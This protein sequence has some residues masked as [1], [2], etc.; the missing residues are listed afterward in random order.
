MDIF[1]KRYSV[2]LGWKIKFTTAIFF[3]KSWICGDFQ[4]FYEKVSDYDDV[5]P[6]SY[7]DDSSTF[8]V[9]DS[10]STY[11]VADS[12]VSTSVASQQECKTEYQTVTEVIY[13]QV[14]EDV[15]QITNKRQC[16]LVPQRKCTPQRQRKCRT[17]TKQECKTRVGQQCADVFQEVSQPFS[18]SECWEEVESCQKILVDGGEGSIPQWINDPDC[19][20][21]LQ[22]SKL[23]MENY[24]INF[25]HN[26]SEKVQRCDEI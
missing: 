22:V 24:I 7:D 18:D 20:F 16:E 6:T 1:D 17:T 19:N 2:T 26:F 13:E 10:P 11:G 3:L 12:Q 5:Y 21:H 14:E 9:I 25:P 8:E 4:T 23:E 15:C